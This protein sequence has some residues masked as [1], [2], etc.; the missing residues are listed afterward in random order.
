M[1]KE[2]LKQKTNFILF[3]VVPSVYMQ[4]KTSDDTPMPTYFHFLA[5]LAFKIFSAEQVTYANSL[6]FLFCFFVSFFPLKELH[7]ISQHKISQSFQKLWWMKLQP[8]LNLHMKVFFFMQVDVAILEV[9]LGGRFD[10]TNVVCL[11]LK[12]CSFSK[13]FTL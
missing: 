1:P 12:N 5:L 13:T 2:N 4:E 6:F 8:M 11:D 10:A 7:R 9:G 3:L